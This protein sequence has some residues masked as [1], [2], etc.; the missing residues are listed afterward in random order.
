MS[1]FVQADGS[2]L[3]AGDF[4]GLFF[5]FS[6]INGN[7]LS[8]TNVSSKLTNIHWNRKGSH[9]LLLVS[10]ENGVR[11]FKKP[12]QPYSTRNCVWHQTVEV[13]HLSEQTPLLVQN[14]VHHT[15]SVRDIKWLTKETFASCALD[16]SI[17]VCRIGNEETLYSL[18]TEV[19]KFQKISLFV[20]LF[21]PVVK[22]VW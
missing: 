19:C 16:G 7:L 11:K 17:F 13:W 12:N 15:S 9:N 14:F 20:L 4:N 22:L 6:A 8:F 1:I 10:C 2:L 18:F 21:A 3:A 5:V